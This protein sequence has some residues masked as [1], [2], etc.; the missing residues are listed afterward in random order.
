M[1]T[2][3]RYE[4]NPVLTAKDIPYECLRCYNPAAI[5]VKDEYILL[6]RVWQ[7]GRRESIALARSKDGYNFT[8]ED[9]PVLTPNEYEKER[10]NDCRVTEVDGEYYICFCTDPDDGIRIGI[11]KTK[12]FHH[13][14]R[15]HYS[16]PDN[17]NAVIF[18]EKINGLYARLE[19]PFA[20]QYFLDRPYDIW[21]S[22]SPDMEFWGRHEKVLGF[23]QVAWGSNKI[24]PGPQPIKTDK[25]WLI[26]YHGA[27]TNDEVKEGWNKIYR[28]GVMLCDLENPAKVIALPP[29][30][31]LSPETDY[32]KDKFYRDNI[33]FPSGVVVEE[34]NTIKIYYGASDNSVCVAET[35][36]DKLLDF[37]LNPEEYEHPVTKVFDGTLKSKHA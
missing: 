1:D 29:K 15:I 34:D 17:R 14:E 12:D 16:L 35:S 9:K 13:F 6:V 19:R 22:Y 30:P 8:V 33:V 24:G 23:E 37:C 2:I 20:R 25:G 36:V 4:K 31:L 32:E 7:E 21:I 11:A 27:E 26:I 28:M 5:K 3:K 10:L 18:P